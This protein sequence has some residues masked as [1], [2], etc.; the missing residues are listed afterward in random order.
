MKAISLTRYALGVAAAMLTAC[1]MGGSLQAPGSVAAGALPPGTTLD[2]SVSARNGLS[3]R[4]DHSQSWMNPDAK[5]RT[6]LYVGDE[7]LNN[8]YVYAYPKGTL[9]GTL[10]G[11][12]TPFGECTDRAGDVWIVDGLRSQLVEY[13]HG[14]TT[15]IATL[16]D[17]GQGP[18]GC[19]VNLQSG[20]L[21]AANYE[22]LSPSGPGSISVYA[23]ARGTPKVYS[24]P[25]SANEIFVGYDKSKLYVVG[26][27]YT[28]G[29]YQLAAFAN[30]KFTDLT[31]SGA[32]IHYP[33]GIGFDNG[34]WI[35][36]GGDGSSNSTNMY[37]VTVSGT[38][39]TVIGTTPLTSGGFCAELAYRKV[40]L[41]SGE[42]DTFT[43]VGFYRYPAGGSPYKSIAGLEAPYGLAISK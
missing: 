13:A 2:Q 22:S 29:A 20:D 38:T 35:G 36:D 12:E 39:A 42:F 4:A 37:Q 18:F 3:R 23:K 28:T 32:T 10:T 21:V 33:G 9:V 8:V 40:A 41:C 7:D 27:K 31:V 26:V 11:F 17:P 30:K 43:G 25:N 19:A 6:L 5:R 15:I 1:T 34:L 14:G 16:Q 24:D